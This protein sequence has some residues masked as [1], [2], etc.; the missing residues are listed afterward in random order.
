M[1]ANDVI[2]PGDEPVRR[3]EGGPTEAEE[4]AGREALGERLRGFR[5]MRRTSLRATAGLAGISPGFLSELE[6]GRANA[7][8]GTLRRIADALGLAVADLFSEDRPVE[9]TVV[10][11]DARPEIPAAGGSR[12]YLLSQRPLRHF[13]AYAGEFDPGA[14]TGDEAYVHGDAQELFLVISGSVRVELDGA[15]HDLQA[16]DSIEY[17]TTVPHR[18]VNTSDEL[19]EVLWLIS[20]PTT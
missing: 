16:G 11:R 2:A 17:S 3:A 5:Q 4:Q 8:I 9:P 12:K 18:V 15:G 7:S 19:A 20:P 10:R 13:E 14:T 1:S 6:R